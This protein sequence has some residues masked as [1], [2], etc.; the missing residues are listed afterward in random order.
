MSWFNFFVFF[1]FKDE[2]KEIL[3]IQRIITL[4]NKQFKNKY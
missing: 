4:K 1:C 3:E 2:G